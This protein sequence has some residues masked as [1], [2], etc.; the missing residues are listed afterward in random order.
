MPDI[1]MCTGIGCNMNGGCYRAMAK[2]SSYQSY[3]ATPPCQ[4]VGVCDF[5]WP[6]TKPPFVK[7]DNNENDIYFSPDD[8]EDPILGIINLG[9]L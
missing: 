2:P 9:V 5:Y 7:Y 8:W 3:F 1:S 4:S 6:T